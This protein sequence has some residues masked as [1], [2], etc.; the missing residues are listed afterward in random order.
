MQLGPSFKA[1]MLLFVVTL[2]LSAAVLYGGAQLVDVDKPA[3][4]ADGQ[5]TTARSSLAA[6][7]R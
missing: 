2:G 7:W 3:A 4:A 6:R 1:G 5:E